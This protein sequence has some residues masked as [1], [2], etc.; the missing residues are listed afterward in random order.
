MYVIY[1]TAV[2]HTNARHMGYRRIDKDIH[3]DVVYI[4]EDETL[5]NKKKLHEKCNS[6]RFIIYFLL[7]FFFFF[8]TSFRIIIPT[9]NSDANYVALILQREVSILPPRSAPPG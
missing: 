6:S 8:F 5:A 4:D 3:I 1:H 7:R 2:T 9:F